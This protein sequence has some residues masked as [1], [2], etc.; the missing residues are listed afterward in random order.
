MNGLALES[1]TV[2]VL[3]EIRRPAPGRVPGAQIAAARCVSVK[4]V[5]GA[6]LSSLGLRM[7][8]FCTHIG[9]APGMAA[10][11][12]RFEGEALADRLVAYMQRWL[13]VG[14]DTKVL[15]GMLRAYYAEVRKKCGAIV[16][17]QTAA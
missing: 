6:Y 7:V 9:S 17:M 11:F 12:A 5:V 8:P 2:E 15:Q 14:L 3:D 1:E 4:P 16:P 13:D 10:L